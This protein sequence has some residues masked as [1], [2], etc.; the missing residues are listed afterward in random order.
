MTFLRLWLAKL[1]SLPEFLRVAIIFTVL[2]V[3][4]TYPAVGNLNK[5]FIGDGGDGY[6]N[7]WNMWWMK[8]ALMDL[9]TTPYF[10]SYL[11]HPTGHT[12]LF[13]TFN[14]F[15]GLISI[16]LQY[17]F[18][19][20]TV[21]NLVVLFSFVAS[22]MGMYY[23]ARYLLNNRLAAFVAG[24]I[25]TFC[26]YHFGHGL[27]HLQL[28]AME[29]L[30]VYT[31]FVIKTFDEGRWRNGVLAGLFLVFTS[32][33]S[34]YY[35]IYAAVLTVILLIPRIKMLL[36]NRRRIA[37]AALTP[38]TFGILLSPLL[39]AMLKAKAGG[40]FIGEHNPEEWSAD[41]VSFFVPSGISTWG[42]SFKSVWSQFSGNM[43]EN[44][45]YFGYVVLALAIWGAAGVRKARFWGIAGVVFLI[46]ALGPYPRIM[47]VQYRIPLPYHVLHSYVPLF[48]FSGVPERFDIMVK[49]CMAIMV[50]C[51]LARWLGKPGRDRSTARLA[52]CAVALAIL[53]EY[54]AVPFQMTHVSVPPFFTEIA[55]DG[56]DYGVIHFPRVK[57]TMY[58]ATVHGKPI[59]GGYMT[60]RQRSALQFLS[61]HP[62][63]DFLTHPYPRQYQRMKS[64]GS[65]PRRA[66]ELFA[67]HN[68][69][70]IFAYRQQEA[71]LLKS[72]FDLRVVDTRGGVWAL[73]CRG[74]PAGG[75]RDG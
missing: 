24:I 71:A 70:Y 52:T 44:S 46:F 65:L 22:G 41:L 19:M 54:S 25:F 45:N 18:D 49:F 28:I 75:K 4:L 69:R 29:W 56:E 13:Q 26:P 35:L 33:C 68:I 10:T 7:V 37:V 1:Q 42:G 60:R 67:E 30:P 62:I 50:A 31:L 20:K 14:P 53:I 66:K 48:S 23:L 55:D 64:I 36:G 51:A 39:V 58:L 16:P 74:A 5:Q 59:V 73:D 11:Y 63:L 27:G 43:A 32:L 2:T 12:L 34:W 21:Y 57:G 38:L 17:L 15:N 47:G 6:Q 61:E 8:T 3:I 40:D 9:G 72:M